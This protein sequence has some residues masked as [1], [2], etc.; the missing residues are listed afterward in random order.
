MTEHLPESPALYMCESPDCFHSKLVC[1]CESL[2]KAEH[3]GYLIGYGA[4]M[5]DG[6]GEPGHIKAALDE[7]A[8][9]VEALPHA[10]ECVTRDPNYK[11]PCNCLRGDALDAIK[12]D[13][14]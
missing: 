2:T 4:A 7:A 11:R 14:P 12:G 9:R 13:Q 10:L 8:Q 3:R 6:W 5:E 1:L